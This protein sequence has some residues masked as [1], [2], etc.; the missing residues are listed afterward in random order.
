MGYVI[1]GITFLIVCA[2]CVVLYMRIKRRKSCVI[3]DNMEQVEEKTESQ[4]IP[5]DSELQEYVIQMEMLPVESISDENKLVEI[6]DSKVLAH[7]NNLVP[8]MAQ[9]GNV[10]NNAVQAAQVN[11]EVLY[12]AIIP[13][14]ARLTDSKAMEGAVRGIYHGTD[15]IRGHA[16]LVATEMQKGTSVVAN[17]AAATMG[18]AS[19]VVGQ[20]YMTQINAELGEI[21]DGIS[22][23]SDFQ[24]NEYRSRVFSLV[25]HVKKIADF[26][27]EILENNELRISKISQLDSLEEE[28][29]QLLGQANLSLVGFTKKTDYDYDTYEKKLLE[30]QNWYMYQKSLLDVL[31]RIS[32]LRY[33]LH[34]G[35]VSRE[36]CITLIPTYS[37][38]VADTKNRLAGWHQANIERLKIDMQELR[39]KRGGF[40]GVIHA[41]PG[42]FNDNLNFK[43]IE[44]DTVEMIEMQTA[45]SA[46]VLK[47]DTSDLYVE[48]VQLIYKDGK[49]YYLP[50]ET[51]DEK[52]RI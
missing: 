2:A 4:I 37:N 11:G 1:I 8:G 50:A 21:S 10:A 33:T 35:T 29:T 28:C 52:L 41:I 31:Y 20:Y 23:I 34:L 16:N 45:D 51:V 14:G 27:I 47:Y 17:T 42:V 46:N 43:T 40:D 48:D 38:Q 30:I 3:L 9:V 25:A 24:D 49:I 15:G 12:R 13:V 22:Q 5:A 44:K 7:I 19:M 18:V 32:E 26:Q 39:R 6:T 36:Q